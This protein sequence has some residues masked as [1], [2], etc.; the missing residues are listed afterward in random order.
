[1]I[2]FTKSMVQYMTL[3]ALSDIITEIRNKIQGF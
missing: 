1:M 3:K 2:I